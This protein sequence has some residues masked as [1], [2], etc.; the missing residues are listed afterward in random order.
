[1]SPPHI[2][3]EMI[4]GLDTVYAGLNLTLQCDVT[5]VNLSDV[6]VDI[7]LEWFKSGDKIKT[8][9]ELQRISGDKFHC[10]MNLTH[11]SYKDDNGSY[12]CI[13]VITP[14]QQYSFLKAQTVISNTLDLN[15]TGKMVILEANSGSNDH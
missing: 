3:L 1:M 14:K 12:S 6:H 8:C 5:L 10:Y 4:E 7:S 9:S 11:L 15:V 2:S 13:A